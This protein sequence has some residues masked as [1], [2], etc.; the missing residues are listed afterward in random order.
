MTTPEARPA[1]AIVFYPYS[2]T[3]VS[4]ELVAL[5][6]PVYADAD[7]ATFYGRNVGV[8]GQLWQREAARDVQAHGEPTPRTKR[9]GDRLRNEVKRK[10]SPQGARRIIA[11]RI[12]RRRLAMRA[13]RAELDALR[14]SRRLEP[15][16]SSM[17]RTALALGLAFTSDDARG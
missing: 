12:E 8:D 13:T 4:P 10:P 11:E 3:T 5:L 15:E 6:V 1:A 7:D 17:A 9:E 2:T 16:P 14:G